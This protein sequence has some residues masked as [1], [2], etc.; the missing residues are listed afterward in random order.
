G[1]LGEGSNSFG[2][3][4]AWLSSNGLGDRELREMNM[5][6]SQNCIEVSAAEVA[7]AAAQLLADTG[8]TQLDI[9]GHSLGGLAARY[10]VKNL[11]GAAV[12]RNFVSITSPQ[13]GT[14]AAT[15]ATWPAC[16]VAQMT[17]TSPFIAALNAGDETPGAGVMYT[18]IRG[19]NDVFVM[20][21]TSPLLAGADNVDT[22]LDHVQVLLQPSNFEV[23]RAALEGAGKNA[24]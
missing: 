9:V 6:N 8:A 24:N 20:P 14:L 10:F 16:S 12:V 21:N 22:W 5:S 18:S 11:G 19:M 13:H 3:M 7:L 4:R 23:V 2:T 1:L 17:V 15:P